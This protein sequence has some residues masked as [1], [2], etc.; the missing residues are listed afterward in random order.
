MK[1]RN[2]IR[3]WIC[4]S[5]VMDNAA[6]SYHCCV[7][8]GIATVVQHSVGKTI[9]VMV[10]RNRKFQL[11]PLVPQKWL[12]AGLLGY[13]ENNISLY[14]VCFR[15]AK[16]L[17]WQCCTSCKG[18]MAACSGCHTYN[19]DDANSAFF[20]PLVPHCFQTVLFLVGVK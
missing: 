18:E 17:T 9:R 2:L 12:G 7:Q 15:L 10:R 3:C 16:R 6:E 4:C 11:I 5:C 8:G 19:F 14:F 1:Q 20:E 13:V